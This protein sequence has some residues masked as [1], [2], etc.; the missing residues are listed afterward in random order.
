MLHVRTALRARSLFAT[1][2]IASI[3]PGQAI[4]L[5]WIRLRSDRT[6]SGRPASNA[7]PI[8]QPPLSPR[9][10]EYDPKRS[11]RTSSQQNKENAE[12]ES[13]SKE[14]AF[15][16][17]DR[18]NTAVGEQ[19]GPDQ[20]EGQKKIDFGQAGDEALSSKANTAPDGEPL[21]TPQV[22]L[23]DLRQGIPSTFEAE[24]LKQSSD[25]SEPPQPQ[26]KAHHELDIT[27]T[28]TRSAHGTRGGR[29]GGGEDDLPK[30]AY[31]TSI[32][33]RRNQIAN[34][35]YMIIAAFGLVGTV[36]LGRN[37]E[38]EEEEKTHPDAPSGWGFKLF[39][40]RIKARMSNSLGYYTEPTF[41]KLL[42]DMEG[43][44]PPYTLVISLEDL[45]I[46]SEWSRQHGWRTAKRPGIDYFLRYL[47]NYYEIVLFTT[48][49]MASAEPILR[50]LDPYQMI[51]WPLFRE[52][53]RYENGEYI[54]VSSL[55]PLFK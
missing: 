37:W 41:P 34:Y 50:K 1:P 46:H 44:L 16:E 52:A 24:F 29:G 12:G 13:G 3:R 21:E 4:P 40:D 5:Q 17:F 51:M 9:E 32:D 15:G 14:R 25:A 43:K 33:K 18:G 22:Q 55:S 20:L 2:R 19:P 8:I 11:F 42:P 26:A 28:H 30:S 6:S 54:K 48:M 47:F 53:T 49:P 27:E 31:E 23:P 45:M 39:W 7:N 38:T 10:L 35:M 36:Y